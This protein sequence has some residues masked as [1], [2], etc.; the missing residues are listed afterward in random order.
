MAYSIE[1]ARNPN[2]EDTPVPNLFITDFMPDVPDGDMVK[3]YIYAYMCCR[4]GIALTHAELADRLGLGIEKVTATWRYF[5]DRC[6]VRL[7]PQASGDEARFDVVF[8]DV[9]GVLYGGGDSRGDAG[10]AG[11][12]SAAGLGEPV[13]AALFQKIAS[14]CGAPTIDGADAQLIISWIEEYGATPEIIE[15]AWLFCR[16]ERGEKNA[17]YVGKVVK[18]WAEKGLKTVSEVRDHRAKTDARSGVHKALMEALGLRY[19]VITNAEEKLF[20]LWIDDYGYT[21]ERLLELAEKTVGVGNKLKYLEGIIRKEREKEGKSPGTRAARTG[22]KDRDEYYRRAREKNEDAAAARRKE[23]Y[24]AIPAIKSMDDEITLLNMEYVKILSS[25]DMSDKQ[26]A[27]K[28]LNDEIKTANTNKQKLLK[29]AG[30]APDHMDVK[31][32]C[33]LCRDTGILENGTS[34]NCFL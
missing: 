1:K 22:M 26:S 9:K 7:V 34:C 2:L 13:F 23:A 25:T 32:D 27:V 3:I 20:N 12:K 10:T 28:R 6:I 18:E 19:S 16:D 11:G 21:A 29:E 17:K 15:F 33:L 5:A 30:F 14:I 24:A 31:H 4:Q 8:V